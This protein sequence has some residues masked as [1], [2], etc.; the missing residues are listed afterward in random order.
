MMQVV[1]TVDPTMF[2]L[3]KA[4]MIP[5]VDVPVFK[6]PIDKRLAM[7][8]NSLQNLVFSS[9]FFGTLN[10]SNKICLHPYFCREKKGGLGL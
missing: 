4:L 8:G 6:D 1:L 2:G 9:K 10:E 3:N 5:V 7:L